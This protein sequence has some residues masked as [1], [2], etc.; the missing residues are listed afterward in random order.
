M[1][2]NII[3]TEDRLQEAVKYFRTQPAFVFDVEAQGEN[4]DVPHLAQLSWMSLATKGATIVVPFGHPIG[5]NIVGTQRV[6]M[7]YKT[8]AKIGQTYYKTEPVYDQ[9][10]EQLSPGVVFRT[11]EPLFF[12]DS[13]IKVGHDV[14]YDLVSTAKYFGAVPYGPYDDTKID[15]W[16]L[17][18][19]MNRYGL[20]ELTRKIYGVDYDTG[21]TGA[22]IESVPFSEAAHYSFCDS[23]YDWLHYNRLKREL[24]EQGLQLIHDIE[25]DVLNVMIGMR[26]AGARVDV[27]MLHSLQ[28]ELTAEL[29]KIKSRIYSQAGSIFNINSVKQKQAVLYSPKPEGQGLQPWKLT[30]GG[31]KKAKL[32]QKV[33]IN[34]Y[35]TDDDVLASYSKNPVAVSLREYG[36]VNKLLTTYVNGW[37][38][39][40]DRP[41][42]IYDEH[43]HAGFLQYGTVTGRFSCRAPNLQNIPRPH[44]ELGRKIRDVFIAEPQGRL[45]VADYGQIELVIL[46][47]YVGEGKLFEGF[48]EGI[49]PHTMT[50][51]MV[52][53]KDPADI[54]KVERQDMGKTMNFAVVYGAG[55]KKV[56]SMANVSEAR[57][58]AILKRH[59]EMFPEVHDFKADVIRR[60]R[61]KK[62]MPY[63]TTLL[64]RRRRVATINSENNKIRFAAERQ[65]FNS[66]I[67]GG[68][69]DL[70]KYA[71]IRVD[72][73][74]PDDIHLILTVHDELVLSAPED[75]AD[76]AADIL[77][78]AMTGSGIQKLV[79]VP[80]QADVH[81]V[82]RWSDAK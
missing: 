41:S 64:G 2:R 66:L 9:P 26:L 53:G 56:A 3:L 15:Q 5:D 63:I 52:L 29:E 7:Q 6:P 16:I 19:N 77:T 31:E 59:E 23:K 67:Q 17:D 33:T 55:P 78:E 57:A 54:T 60:C 10:P 69:A 48:L 50:A 61:S 21:N 49:D 62:P 14:I 27:Q 4:R 74:L 30:A 72:S 36:D 68:A 79:R 1:N 18:E 51:A 37:L 11:L 76:V 35:S 22:H 24:Q 13:I 8:G 42:L 34:D 46:A 71:M 39:D 38:G 73:L 43:I 75:R 20:K 82:E 12:D 44:S 25:M 70:L 80:L 65:V 28:T 45:V 47:H 58:R 32:G 40:E 81:I